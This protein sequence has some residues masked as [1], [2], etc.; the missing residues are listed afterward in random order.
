MARAKSERPVT[1]LVGP[2]LEAILRERAKNNGRSLTKEAVFLI[3]TALACTSED[4]RRTL[5]VLYKAGVEVTEEAT[6]QAV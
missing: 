5:H 2:E 3:E 6:P 1:V 4:V